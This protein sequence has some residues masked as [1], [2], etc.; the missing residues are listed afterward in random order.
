SLSASHGPRWPTESA[1]TG[2]RGPATA[3]PGPP[4]S[5]ATTDRPDDDRSERRREQAEGLLPRGRL[6]GRTAGEGAGARVQHPLVEV[7]RRR[8]LGD[9]LA[10]LVGRPDDPA[11]HHLLGE[12]EV[13]LGNAACLGLLEQRL[14]G[15]AC[16][17]A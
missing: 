1:S 10:R 6:I 15:A 14:R 7:A 4:C 5:T 8:Q 11:L 13:L 17:R 3:T 2:R 9:L 12:R 16:A